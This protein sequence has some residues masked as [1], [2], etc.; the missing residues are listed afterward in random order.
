M[1]D[2]KWR[3]FTFCRTF[4]FFVGCSLNPFGSWRRLPSGHSVPGQCPVVRKARE[5][6]WWKRG[7]MGSKRSVW[8]RV[9]LRMAKRHCAPSA[10]IRSSGNRPSEKKSPARTGPFSGITE[11]G[12]RSKQQQPVGLKKERVRASSGITQRKTCPSLAT[13]C[14]LEEMEP[15]SEIVI[16]LNR[17]PEP[18]VADG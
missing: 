15:P 2:S 3:W 10:V 18:R 8:C 4:L 13:G 9:H 5:A 11:Q 14:S 7:T 12:Y 17:A 6:L 1:G 16:V